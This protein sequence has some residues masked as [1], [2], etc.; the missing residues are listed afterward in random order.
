MRSARGLI[1]RRLLP[2][3][4]AAVSLG[5]LE[6]GSSMP[7]RDLP[8]TCFLSNFLGLVILKKLNTGTHAYM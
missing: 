4:A 1:C 6:E 8:I 3:S 2:D 5:M 7:K